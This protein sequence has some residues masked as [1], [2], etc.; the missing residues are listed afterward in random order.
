MTT[1]E[2]L[3]ESDLKAFLK[4]FLTRVFEPKNSLFTWIDGGRFEN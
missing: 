4:V 2:I 1:R 3:F